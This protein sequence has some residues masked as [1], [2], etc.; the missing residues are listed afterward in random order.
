[1]T[2]STSQAGRPA[3]PSALS[4]ALRKWAPPVAVFIGVLII[5]EIYY[6]GGGFF[7]P[8]PTPSA[9]WGALREEW[10]LLS[11][12]AVATIF[13]ALG[14]LAIGTTAGLVVGFLTSRW[15]IARDLSGDDYHVVAVIGDGAITGGM[16]L[17]GLNQA[18]HLG[19]RL[20]VVL[21]DNGMSISPTVGA[22][23]RLL[24]KVR[25]DSRYHRVKEQGK[26]ILNWNSS[27]LY[28]S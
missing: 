19:S 6:S 4:E 23:A 2:A 21:N 22:I 8:I 27:M 20:I 18:G 10:E 14:G 7:N 26:R 28:C 17:E 11:S 1:M 25:F 24:G 12:S 16:A 9:I 5:W 15:A 3:V 13:E